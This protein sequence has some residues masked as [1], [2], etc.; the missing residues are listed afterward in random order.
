MEILK[1][2]GKLL[3]N[4]DRKQVEARR[5][6]LLWGNELDLSLP[7]GTPLLRGG[8]VV[9]LGV[10]AQDVGGSLYLDLPN[11]QGGRVIYPLETIVGTRTDVESF[12]QAYQRDRIAREALLTVI[13]SSR[14]CLASM[15]EGVLK[16]SK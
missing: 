6:Y 14:Q 3:D 16:G 8:R 9:R 11:N 12:Q 2:V 5:V 15:I 4:R 7:D 10:L 1:T 13:G